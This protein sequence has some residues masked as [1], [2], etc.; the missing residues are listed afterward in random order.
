LLNQRLAL[1]SE[2][3]NLPLLA[4]G[5]RGIE[6]ETLRVDNQGHLA[7]TPHPAALGS[8]LTHEKITTDYS[9]S[10][11]EFITPARPDV[12]E[13]LSCLDDVHRFVYA[14][15]DGE[16]MWH[17]SM[18]CYLP[19]EATIPIAWYG[20]SHIGMLKHVYR[21]GLAVR[22]GK[23]MQCIAGLHYNFSLNEGI[24]ALLH[25]AEGTECGAMTARDY[26]SARYIALVR[27]FRRY[28]WLLMYLFGASPALAANFLAGR[29]HQLETL[30][31]DTLYLPYATSLRMSDL[32]YQ[33]N[34]QAGITPYYNHLDGYIKSLTEAVSQPYP[35]YEA[36]GTKQDGQW[37][38]LNTN[39]LQIENEYYS[40]I[41]P[42]RTIHSGERPLPALTQ[43]G[44]QYV[45]V[46][47]MDIDPFDGLGITLE[48]ARF[49]DVFLHYI[50][51]E[52]SPC[53]EEAEGR[54]CTNNFALTV[55]EG[56]RPGLTLTRDGQQIGLT[57]WGHELIAQ[58]APVAALLDKQHGSDV[59]TRALAA[60]AAKLNN[61]SLTPSARVLEAI[62]AEGGSFIQFTRKQSQQQA[63]SLL[64]RP[65]SA[66]MNAH[67]EAL[68]AESLKAQTAIEQSDTGSFDEFVATYNASV[69]V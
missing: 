29:T 66:E 47:C 41:R 7:L 68:A 46:R 1:L 32:G 17:A 4:K 45:E 26:Q 8:A 16:H 34:A 58:M 52:D 60:Q 64:A 61:V 51:L 59:H 23:R 5:L 2:P 50:A 19:D 43:R 3:A 48:T 22:Y 56:R 40:S 65:L 31:D 11:L 39:I 53:M 20:T 24:W 15:L 63:A 9:E 27:N 30:S 49:L 33:S 67:F 21:R 44:V 36:I 25:N 57:D 6:R 14:R 37:I 12:A 38:Q 69:T 62:R 10:L 54:A 18:P 13:V 42:K 35:E 55:K 28:S